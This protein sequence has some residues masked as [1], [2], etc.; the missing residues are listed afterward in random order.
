MFLANLTSGQLNAL[1][2]CCVVNLGELIEIL[3]HLRKAVETISQITCVRL[4][5]SGCASPSKRSYIER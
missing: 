5:R 1:E 3:C 4:R 2:I